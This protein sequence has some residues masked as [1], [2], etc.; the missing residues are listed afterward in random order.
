LSARRRARCGGVGS[1]RPQVDQVQGG[2]GQAGARLAAAPRN[3]AARAWPGGPA[4]PSAGQRRV[5]AR[6]RPRGRGQPVDARRSRGRGAGQ[7]LA[8]E[9]W[10]NR[11]G[12]PGPGPADHQHAEVSSRRSAGSTSPPQTVEQHVA[13]DGSSGSAAARARCP[14]GGLRR[15]GSTAGRRR[16]WAAG[17]WRVVGRAV[18]GEQFGEPERLPRC[19]ARTPR[20]ASGLRGAAV[21]RLDRAPGLRAVTG[22]GA[23]AAPTG[24]AELRSVRARPGR[25]RLLRRG[26]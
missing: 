17:R 20:T 1:R 8:Q 6:A 25:T 16:A 7:G 10:R 26:L 23:R 18:C 11:S 22:P 2:G 24:A 9:R 19:G 21:V 12:P 14:T 5:V 13:L 15:R 3:R 4:R